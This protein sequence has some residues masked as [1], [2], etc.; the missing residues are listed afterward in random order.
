MR[1][2]AIGESK[3]RTATKEESLHPWVSEGRSGLRPLPPKQL[4]IL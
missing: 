2:A 4:K 1:E 3:R